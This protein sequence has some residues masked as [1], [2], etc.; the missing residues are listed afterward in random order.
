MDQ[1]AAFRQAILTEPDDH[2][3]R[4][5]YAD[6]LQEHEG[7]GPHVELLRRQG[8]LGPSLVNSLG[9]K[10]VPIPAG[11]FRMGSP[12]DEEGRDPDEQEH[13]V[14]LT[15][16]YRLAAHPVTVG[17]FRD[18]VRTTR[19]QTAA[20][21]DGE[22][23]IGWNA[24]AQGWERARGYAW[25]SPGWQ[26]GEDHP[27]VL[28]SWADAVHFC[29]WLTNTEQRTYRLP[30]EAEWER[31]CRGGSQ[32][33]FWWG[34]SASS[35]QANFNGAEP[36]GDADKGPALR[37]TAP[38]GSYPANPFGLF[39]THGNAWEWCFDGY[40]ANYPSGPATDPTGPGPTGIGGRVL[41]GG[42]W[43]DRGLDCRSAMRRCGDSPWSRYQDGNRGLR[44]LLEM[45]DA[46][47]FAP[48]APKKKRTRR[49]KP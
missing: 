33:P 36:Y 3:Q 40:A 1:H 48:P 39:D 20:E 32:T 49:R 18:F 38:V 5:I 44:V 31:A 16:P 4:L 43:C 45:P 26:Q 7:D 21:R 11:A 22:G 24:R 8:A 30:T 25:H 27:V 34:A 46:P 10:L 12:S 47:S 35:A 14:T 28:L 6:W 2:V 23:A 29:S 42:S 17:Q 9:M 15:R 37:R 13:E 41:R 19:Y